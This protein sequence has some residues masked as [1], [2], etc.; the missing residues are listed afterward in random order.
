[1]ANIILNPQSGTPQSSKSISFSLEGIDVDVYRVR[2]ENTTCKVA[3]LVKNYIQS[4]RNCS[5]ELDIRIG[6]NT[7]ESAF[8][9]FF[10]IEVPTQDGSKWKIH[11]IYP[12]IFNLIEQKVSF[13]GSLN[14]NPL[15]I[16]PSDIGSITIK[17]EKS[18]KI[19]FSINNKKLNIYTDNN[20][21]GSVHFTGKDIFLNH[22]KNDVNKYP[23]YYYLSDDNYVSK[24][25]SGIYITALPQTISMHASADPRCDPTNEAYIINGTWVQPTECPTDGPDPIEPDVDGPDVGEPTK[26][27]IDIPSSCKE[28]SN[29]LDTSEICHIHNHSIALLDNGQVAHAYTYVDKSITDPANVRY[30]KN[31]VVVTVNNSSVDVQ[32]IAIQDI[33]V[34]SKTAGGQFHLYVTEDL[35]NL[36]GIVEDI[37]GSDIVVTLYDKTIGYNKIR[38]IERTIDEYTASYVLIGEM[39]NDNL[40]IK[41]WIF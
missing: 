10:I 18:E 13:N 4:G 3:A 19:I 17:I 40:E 24:R 32:I 35:F 11:D 6:E 8:S 29:I 21:E 2:V 34:A 25:F 38:I 15:F 23:V 39:E 14:V 31:R 37:S 33:S 27:P 9:L 30:N 28:S 36:L 20:G 5:G 26:P 1:M 22:F 16:G 7:T 12:S 41:G